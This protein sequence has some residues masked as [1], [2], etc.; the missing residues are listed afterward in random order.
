MFHT[1]RIALQTY[2]HLLTCSTANEESFTCSLGRDLTVMRLVY[3]IDLSFL[4]ELALT[5]LGR[6]VVKI[7]SNSLQ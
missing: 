1:N 4:N 7:S 3:R 6:R 5:N 2:M